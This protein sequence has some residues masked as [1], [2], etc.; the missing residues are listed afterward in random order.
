MEKRCLDRNEKGHLFEMPFDGR[1]INLRYHGLFLIYTKMIE[2]S[3]VFYQ[4]ISGIYSKC[5][6]FASG[7]DTV[8]T[9]GRSAAFKIHCLNHD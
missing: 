4:K 9:R 5:R 2:K 6:L 8:S 3:K 1:T 7:T